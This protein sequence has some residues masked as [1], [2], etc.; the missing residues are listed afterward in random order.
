MGAL[1]KILSMNALII[2]QIMLGLK[3]S[4]VFDEFVGIKLF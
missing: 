2:I 4:T 1:Q 3:N